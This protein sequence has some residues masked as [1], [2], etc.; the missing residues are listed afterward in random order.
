M[1]IERIESKNLV[2]EKMSQDGIDTL[3]LY[4]AAIIKLPDTDIRFMNHGYL[5]TQGE[6]LTWVAPSDEREKYSVN[7]YRR[8]LA[9]T[10]VEAKSVL[11]VGSGRGGGCSFFSR[12]TEAS[13]VVGVDFCQ[14]NILFSQDVFSSLSN[15]SF[16][17]GDALSLPVET[18]SFDI[19]VNLESSHC[20]PKMEKFLSEVHRVLSSDGVFC[21]ADLIFDSPQS[22]QE[23]LVEAGFDVI[24]FEDMTPHVIH[25]LESN[26]DGFTKWMQQ[27]IRSELDNEEWI[28]MLL[29][30]IHQDALGAYQSG[31]VRYC[32]WQL[33]RVS[34]R[35]H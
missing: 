31:A 3:G 10:D 29:K 8:L 18:G 35:K 33:A 14:G 15:V 23:Q 5:S 2:Q 25:A 28:R 19:V 24:D 20:Y 32:R 6:D 12:Y 16:I 22:R 9:D 34:H 17:Y 4:D 26:R 13:R 27:K 30:G 7:L 21:Y 11:E 1:G